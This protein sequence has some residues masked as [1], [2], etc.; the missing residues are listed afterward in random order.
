MMTNILKTLTRPP[1]NTCTEPTT[2]LLSSVSAAAALCVAKVTCVWVCVAALFHC[3]HI[4]ACPPPATPPSPKPL[5]EKKSYV[6]LGDIVVLATCVPSSQKVAYSSLLLIMRE[7]RED[8]KRKRLKK[9][10]NSRLKVWK[11]LVSAA[12]LFHLGCCIW[13]QAVCPFL[14]WP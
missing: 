13:L 1:T 6:L 2:V 10:I 7:C 11:I 14:L 4:P 12:H 5:L 9:K 8:D 3:T